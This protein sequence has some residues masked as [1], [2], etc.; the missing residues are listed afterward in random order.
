[1][2]Y[3]F[4]KAQVTGAGL[5]PASHCLATLKLDESRNPTWTDVAEEF[6][7][8]CR[9]LFDSTVRFNAMEKVE[10]MTPYSEDALEHISKR[11]LPAMGYVM[12]SIKEEAE[13][14]VLPMLRGFETGVF[15]PPPGIF[16]RP[17][18]KE[19]ETAQD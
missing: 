2:I 5:V 7:Q 17:E 18:K 16:K 8:E 13:P 3:K 6:Q 19:E 9:S 14:K 12:M 10:P 1:M 4:Y 11:Q 15:T